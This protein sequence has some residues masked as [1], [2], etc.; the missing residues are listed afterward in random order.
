M[1]FL[2]LDLQLDYSNTFATKALKYILENLYVKLKVNN[3]QENSGKKFLDYIM[4][5]GLIGGNQDWLPEWDMHMGGCAA[6]AGDV[7]MYLAARKNFSSLYP[8][9]CRKITRSDFVRFSAIMKPYLTPRYHGIDFL[10]IY[11][12]GLSQYWRD[13]KFAD[14][15]LEG[16]SGFVNFQIAREALI[17]QIDRDLP[18][19]Y[20]ML[21]HSDPKFDELEWHWFILGGYELHGENI[22]ARVITYGE[23]Y[24]VDFEKLWNTGQERRG[25]L[26]RIF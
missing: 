21:N 10:E 24:M 2:I 22:F 16:L 4:I 8:F 18:V 1:K 23:D 17:D 12:L 3:L 5:D 15:K 11:L 7:C 19:P 14:Y 26:V 13:V 25:G 20:L 9:D 6:V